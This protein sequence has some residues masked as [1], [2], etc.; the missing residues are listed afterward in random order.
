M[1]EAPKRK[2]RWVRWVLA[3]PLLIALALYLARDPI[4]TKLA[5]HALAKRGT[6]CE[7]LALHV[8]WALQSV[9]IDP[10]T[11]TRAEGRVT[12]IAFA[13]GATLELAGTTPRRVVAPEVRVELR[14]APERLEDAGLVLFDE[15]LARPPLTSVLTAVANFAAR[16]D[17]VDLVF[18]R[19]VLGREGRALV[20]RG[21]AARR[22]EEGMLITV[23]E[24]G[25]RAA[26][27][28]AVTDHPADATDSDSAE[29]PAPADSIA[30][31]A[32][33]E[34]D[35]L[36]PQLRWSLRALEARATSDVLDGR[37]TLVVDASI[38]GLGREESIGVAVRGRDLRG[39]PDVSLTLDGSTVVRV[40]RDRARRFRDRLLNQR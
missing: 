20:A 21:V 35:S 17:R 6:S 3:F 10:V 28:D 32:P 15:A 31:E 29:A 37:A 16:S 40:L 34:A 8:G 13:E 11:C 24:L 39:P 18:E 30:P 22:T 1:T 36:G 14:E 2:R 9:A 12:E 26:T 27:T 5:I 25:P 23:D 19:V 7:G 38:A 33:V 4:A